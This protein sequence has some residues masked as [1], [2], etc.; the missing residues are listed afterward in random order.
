MADKQKIHDFAARYY[1]LYTDS[2]PD[3]NSLI[4]DFK[5]QCRSFGFIMDH[6]ER[7]CEKYSESAY[8]HAAD[9]QTII[10]QI[11]DIDLLGSAIFSHFR[12]VT[13]FSQ[14]INLLKEE[15]RS[16]FAIAFQRLAELTKE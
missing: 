6:G 10:S 16:W 8:I 13:M 9:L 5:H 3:L 15:H 11:D 2:H 14:E 1:F 4:T 7:F 12:S